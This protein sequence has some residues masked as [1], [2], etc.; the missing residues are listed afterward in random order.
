M[1]DI[2][3]LLGVFADKR[4]RYDAPFTSAYSGDQ[5]KLRRRLTY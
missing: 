1:L 4:T 5:I 3:Y 2:V